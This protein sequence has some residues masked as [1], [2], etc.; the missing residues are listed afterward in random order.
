VDADAAGLAE[1]VAD[2]RTRNRA[3]AHFVLRVVVGVNLAM[4]GVVRLLAGPGAFAERLASDFEDTA[5]PRVLVVP[6]AH[7][8]PAV[9]L[10]LGLAILLG[11]MQRAALIS[12]GMLMALL[13]FGMALR[14]EWDVVALQLVYALAYYVLLARLHD[15]RTSAERWLQQRR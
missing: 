4:H 8:L 15:D 11:V 7:A 1:D 2:E 10:V 14:Q 9:E 3:W 13:T 6:F 12:A 5:L